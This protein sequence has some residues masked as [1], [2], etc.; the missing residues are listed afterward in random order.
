MPNDEDDEDLA[1]DLIEN[2][3]VTHAQAVKF[4]FALDLLNSLRV[5]SICERLNAPCYPS[6]YRTVGFEVSNRPRRKLYPVRQL[7]A[8]LFLDLLP[9]YRALFFTSESASR[10]CLVLRRSDWEQ[11]KSR[12]SLHRAYR[13][14]ASC[15]AVRSLE[16]SRDAAENRFDAKLQL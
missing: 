2:P 7:D 3:I 13:R 5:R 9:R 8:Q 1:L 15:V 4:L 6:P 16:R 10:A 11:R 14:T 12:P